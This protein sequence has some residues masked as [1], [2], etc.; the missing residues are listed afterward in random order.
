M[1]QIN[2]AAVAEEAFY[3]L[4][5]GPGTVQDGVVYR[6]VEE[7]GELE[8][9]PITE[10]VLQAEMDRLKVIH[11][12]KSERASAY[13]DL[14]EQLDQLWHAM[15]ADEALRLEPFYTTIKTVKDRFPKDG[16][17]NTPFEITLEEGT[18]GE[19]TFTPP[20]P[21]VDYA[22]TIFSQTADNNEA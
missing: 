6:V 9:T 4:L 19:D 22:E 5:G 7:T 20:D 1:T 3:N 2:F 13:P 12:Y 15:D 10:A 16:S 8:A 21:S 11:Q 14:A 17:G 18:T